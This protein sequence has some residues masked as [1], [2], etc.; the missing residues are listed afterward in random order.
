M[1]PVMLANAY[2]P[3]ER[4]V[5]GSSRKSKTSVT[6][7]RWAIPLALA[8]IIATATPAPAEPA[9]SRE[10]PGSA[11]GSEPIDFDVPPQALPS[12]LTSF[13]EQSGLELAYGAELAE[14]RRMR[15]VSGLH[16]HGE[17]LDIFLAGTG[18]VYRVTAAGGVTL[19]EEAEGN[20][21]TGF[22]V[23]D[24]ITVEAKEIGDIGY[25]SGVART[26]T[27][28]PVS[29]L[30]TPRS[31]NV[32][33]RSVIEDRA[34]LDPLE[35]IQNVSGVQRGVSRTGVSESYLVRGFAQQ[36]LFKDGFRA[37]SLLG[38][39][40]SRSRGQPTSRTSS[41]SRC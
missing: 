24:P 14:G 26:A 3:T 4:E 32:V 9:L 20:A 25:A 18:V 35:A 23:L 29:I 31:V 10:A 15:G 13:G 34:I 21:D 17:A 11:P 22:I 41:A 38:A 33:P 36:A 40:S 7:L 8:W 37:G 12:A 39:P 2:T 30:E 28:S 6:K 27:R 19:A 16:P 1:K 5:E